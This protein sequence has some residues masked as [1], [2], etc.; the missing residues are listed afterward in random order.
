MMKDKNI[1]VILSFFLGMFGAHRFYL[2]QTKL[3]ILYCVLS[4]VG[5]SVLLQIID[6]FVFLFMDRKVFDLKYNSK[7]VDLQR[8]EDM[9]EADDYE[10]N[11]QQRNR[12]SSQYQEN[13]FRKTAPRSRRAATPKPDYNKMNPYKASGIHRYKAYEY[14]EAIEDFLKVLETEPNDISVH[15]NLSCANSLLEQKEEAYY[16]LN[17]AI[18][19]GF[20]DYHRIRNH[21]ALAYL[22]LQPEY[23]A[24]ESRVMNPRKKAPE[25]KDLLADT[26]DLLEQIKQL[27][28]LRERG[29]LT[30]EE[31]TIQKKKLL[32]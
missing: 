11:R 19:L 28:S 15:F 10:Y 26:P 21:D 12:R 4:L 1:V 7:Y 3:G 8:R 6:F 20:K 32:G 2:G 14:E 24:L 27:G 29:L 17:R 25:K 23:E 31:F 16:H 22:R 13:D 5:I 9:Y 18:E 30:E